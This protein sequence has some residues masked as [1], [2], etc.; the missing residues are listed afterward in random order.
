M[1]AKKQ[2]AKKVA[3]KTTKKVVAKKTAAPK[4]VVAKKVATKRKTS[5]NKE[6]RKNQENAYFWGG[7]A[8]ALC[9]AGAFIVFAFGVG[10]M[11]R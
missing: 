3:K 8:I 1:V 5:V 4:K 9:A 6:A 10:A 11:I 2:P 7:L